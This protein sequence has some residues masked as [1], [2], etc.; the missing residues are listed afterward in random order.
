MVSA[1]LVLEGGG[2]RGVYT[3][4]VLEY[5]LEQNLYFPYN[6]GV[7]AGACN[8]A[9]YL[10]RQNGRNKKVNIDF[11]KHPEYLSFR[12]FIKKRQL[13]GMDFI[14]DKIPNEL[15]PFD[16][17]TFYRAEE[18][19]EIGTTDCVTGETIYFN[20]KHHG[21]DLLTII[22][23]SSSLPFAAPI[24][25]YDNRKLLDGGISDPIPLKRAENKGYSKNVVILTR[26]KGYQK[27]SSK[28][29]WLSSKIYRN[30]PGLLDQMEHRATF[31]NET[32]QYISTRES[33]GNV[34]VIQPRTPL[35]VGRVERNRDRLI[36][37]YNEGYEDGKR[38]YPALISWLNE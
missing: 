31:Y 21:K 12:N 36:E 3:A 24:V 2:M 20:N 35:K 32:L 11:I 17:D 26:N 7:S 30:Y 13:F 23:A 33:E 18:F 38:L 14:F 19:F 28:R 6:V 4:G 37:L 25:S 16:F 22:R 34:F 8:A 10:S 15:V 29:S 1:G 5:L 9:S 27:N